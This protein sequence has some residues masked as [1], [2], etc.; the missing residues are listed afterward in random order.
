MRHEPRL[1]AF[2]AICIILVFLVH[3]K[4][5][6]ECGWLGVPGFFVLS[7]FLIT[8]IL[9]RERGET[10]ARLFF[11][12]FYARRSLRIFP[13]YFAY[14]LALV[15][16]TH[17][18]DG[19]FPRLLRGVLDPNLPYLLTYTHNF[20]A[21]AGG[22]AAVLYSHLW[23]LSVE[24]QFYLLWPLLVYLAPGRSLLRLCVGAIVAALL[25]RFSELEFQV[26]LGLASVKTAGPFIYNFS[27]SHID[28]FAFGALLTFRH[29]SPALRR[30]IPV[31]SKW[32]PILFVVASGWML[33]LGSLAGYPM[34]LSSLGW[35]VYLPYFYAYIWGY[36]LL[37]ALFFVVLANL[38]RL[39]A[40]LDRV[41]LQRL[42]KVSYGFYI[43][44][45]AGIG[46]TR[47]LMNDAPSRPG[48]YHLL[49]FVV[50]F[51]TTWLAAELSFR[52]FESPIMRLKALFRPAPAAAPYPPAVSDQPAG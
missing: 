42:G 33:L 49:C 16:V 21:M 13:L 45:K 30:L 41:P 47:I 46:L 10:G 11:V 51:A 22:S 17:L 14:V 5:M 37:N 43:F 23:S 12:N 6:L 4:E 34:G 8:G 28:A 25:I 18:W 15:A 24:E 19:D 38:E 2:R 1:D 39:G 29:E 52:F 31:L 26:R 36:T 44:H 9:R 48:T 40:V 50:A 27:G 35:P 7:G 32:V 3:W 20:Y